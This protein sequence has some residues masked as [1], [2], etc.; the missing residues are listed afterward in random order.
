MHVQKTLCREG[1]TLAHGRFQAH[2]TI[3]VCSAGC[4][5]P[6]GVRVIRGSGTLAEHLPPGSNLGYDVMV[7]VGLQRFL[8]HRQ[9]DEIRNALLEDYGLFV[10]TGEIRLFICFRPWA[11][12]ER[13]EW[14]LREGA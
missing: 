14:E 6:S 9:R 12:A 11:C 13:P 8:R 4:R 7:F 1:R 3:Y 10:S 2:E 5:H